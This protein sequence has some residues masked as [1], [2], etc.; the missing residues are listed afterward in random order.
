ML[1]R[2]KFSKEPVLDTVT[3]SIKQIFE[4]GR[5]YMIIYQ[6]YYGISGELSVLVTETIKSS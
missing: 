1:Q 4:K 3:E 2:F 6:P 5:H